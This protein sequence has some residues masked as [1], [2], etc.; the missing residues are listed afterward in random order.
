MQNLRRLSTVLY[1][2]HCSSGGKLPKSLKE[3]GYR[4]NEYDYCVMKIFND[5][6]YTMLC[7]VDDLNI[8]HV[9]LDIVS[10]ILSDI[11]AKYGKIAEIIIT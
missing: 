7:H 11:D 5:K 3:M 10:S 8:S 6:Q 1:M 9:D 2:H 4:I